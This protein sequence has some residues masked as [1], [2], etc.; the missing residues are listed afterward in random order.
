MSGACS[1]STDFSMLDL[2]GTGELTAVKLPF[3]YCEPGKE[4]KLVTIHEGGYQVFDVATD[5][6]K[7]VTI[8]PLQPCIGV[9]ITDGKK[10]LTFHKSAS[11]SLDSMV[12]IIKENLD[13][14]DPSKICA[15]LY[16]VHNALM[17]SDLFEI[18]LHGGRT[19]Q[20]EVKRIKDKICSECKVE[21][22]QVSASL[23]HTPEVEG[24]RSE[25]GIYRNSELYLA[26]N[27]KKLFEGAD[28]D[29]SLNLV[30][31]CP[32]A[33]MYK[34]VVA[35]NPAWAKKFELIRSAHIIRMNTILQRAY[36]KQFGKTHIEMLSYASMK[37][38]VAAS[39][40][41]PFILVEDSK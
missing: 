34:V 25:L 10:L 26:V 2:H 32:L 33:E 23:F 24:A 27:I 1:S 13:L 9:V 3:P 28:T 20:E 12:S 17:W 31:C 21:R 36:E 39:E 19:H 6:D 41:L 22:G 5:T 30:T 4:Q 7:V 38:A 40:S 14:S 11:C 29:K 16:T 18:A 15:K 37:E 8:G 35:K